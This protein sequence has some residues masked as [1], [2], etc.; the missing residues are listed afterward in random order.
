MNIRKKLT[1]EEFIEL[2]R[3]VHGGKYDYSKTVYVDNYT[4][5]CIICPEH[6]EF[7]QTPDNHLRGQRCRIC[8]NVLKSEKT[9]KSKEQFISDAKEKHGIKYDYSKVEYI[10]SATKVCIVCPKH[11]EFWQRPNA[12]LNGRGCS[13][14]GRDITGQKVSHSDV[15]QFI[16]RAREI[17]GDK[18]DYSLVELKNHTKK[19]CIVCPT[20]GKFMQKPLSHLD[21][22]GCDKCRHDKLRKI[23]HGVG[24][25][26]VHD[27]KARCP[28]YLVWAAMIQR[29]YSEE[30]QKQWPT[31][32]DCSV[33]EEWH[34][35][36]NFKKWF[37]NP[38]NGYRKGYHID[39]DI[40]IKGNRVYSPETCCFVP[41]YI[42]YLFTNRAPR[43]NGL[44]RGV[45]H[46][47][48]KRSD[49]YYYM[50]YIYGKR[51]IS[52]KFSSV[53]EAQVAYSQYKSNHIKALAIEYFNRGE[54]TERVF[55]ALMARAAEGL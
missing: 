36:S 20:H 13:R 44:P 51:I 29:C 37:Y 25:N 31:Y 49:S 17:H 10:N 2:A 6:G 52:G 28:A 54:I 33:C 41:P 38:D 34:L 22:Q 35:F 18:Y 39:K 1:A 40:I 32:K 21:G 9:R 14:C 3:K 30:L 7:W 11:G 42:N 4:K 47:K 45:Y 16:K 26:D 53:E 15:K 50:S 8:A 48:G 55:N 43:S 24:I 19:V 46:R 12:H 23:I 27:E 5:V